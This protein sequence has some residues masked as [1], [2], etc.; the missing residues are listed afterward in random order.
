MK[1]TRADYKYILKELPH[2]NNSSVWALEC[3]PNTTQLPFINNTGC[4]YIEMK[5]GTSEETANEIRN[6]L[7]THSSF[8]T[9]IN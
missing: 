9:L 6:L 1:T 4:L 5:P 3:S 7:N 8:L 2:S